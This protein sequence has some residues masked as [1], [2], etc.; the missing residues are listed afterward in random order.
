[1]MIFDQGNLVEA[2]PKKSLL[3]L[4]FDGLF[5]S[6]RLQ[7]ERTLRRYDDVVRRI[8]LGIA[9]ELELRQEGSENAEQ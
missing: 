1:M 6:R 5:R 4:F 8:R 9:R 3:A 7:A 2:R